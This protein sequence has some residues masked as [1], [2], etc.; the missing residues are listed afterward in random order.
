[1]ARPFRFGTGIFATSSAQAFADSAKR[2]ESL[3]YDVF[4]MPDHF[5]TEGL[6]PVPA[7]LAAANATR[8]LRVG[9]T[10]FDNDFRHPALLAK[11]A[12]TLD[13]L[14]AGRLEFGLG[15]GWKKKEY[16]QVGLTWDEAGVRVSRLEEA[17][18]LIKR[19]WSGAP[20]TFHGEHYHVTDLVNYPRPVQTPHPPVFIGGGGRRLLSIAAKEADIVGFIA[21]ALPRGGLDVGA[22]SDALLRQKIEWVREAAGERMSAIE[23]Q[24][25]IWK[26]AVT[27]N[28]ES[29][30]GEV[31]RAYGLPLEH[32]LGSPY[33]L[34]GSADAIVEQLLAQRT[35][36]GLSYFVVYPE[37]FDAFA[38]VVARL[39]GT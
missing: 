34:I 23:L 12:A 19:L 22:D 15:A 14:S 10:V 21:K 18:Q 11:E 9:S 4:V 24:S 39:R 27:D 38:P 6:A 7:L 32:V 33:F 16:D 17:I 25:L 26:V 28:R 5:H 13:L 2:I 1:M 37:D 35:T 3:G 20:V 8:D 30:A 31:A 36:Y 29:R